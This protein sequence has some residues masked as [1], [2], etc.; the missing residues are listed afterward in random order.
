MGIDREGFIKH[1][2][3][4]AALNLLPGGAAGVL[5]GLEKSSFPKEDV[6]VVH[7][8]VGGQMFALGCKLTGETEED[9]KSLR[10]LARAQEMQYRTET[11]TTEL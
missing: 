2:S 5:E 4:V 7:L 8:V 11:G 6:A 10:W 1:V 3:G 9:I